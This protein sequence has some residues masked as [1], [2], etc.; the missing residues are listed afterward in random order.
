MVDELTADQPAVNPSRLQRMMGIAAFFFAAISSAC[1]WVAWLLAAAGLGT[2]AAAGFEPFRPV[3]LV[4]TL[5]LI[6]VANIW[7][8]RKSGRLDPPVA[9]ISIVALIVAFLHH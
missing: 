9:V 7:A 1:C 8:Y 3:A 2:S 4:A 6:A 5:V